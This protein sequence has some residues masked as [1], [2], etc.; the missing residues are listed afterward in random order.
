VRSLLMIPKRSSSQPATSLSPSSGSIR[1]AY[2]ISSDYSN[3]VSGGNPM[4]FAIARSLSKPGFFI[5]PL[6][7]RLTYERVTTPPVAS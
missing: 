6:R 4:A 5:L 1:T 7:I 2:R 3:Q